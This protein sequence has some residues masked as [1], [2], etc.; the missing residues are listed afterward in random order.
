MAESKGSRRYGKGPKIAA[1]EEMGEK[2]EH[3]VPERDGD[4]GPKGSVTS[5]TDGIETRREEASEPGAMEPEGEGTMTEH[6]HAHERGAMHAKH[7]HELAQMHAKHEHE[8]RMREGGH[9]TEGHAEMHA[10]HHKE[11]QALHTEHEGEMKRMH[12]RH[13]AGAMEKEAA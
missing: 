3:T 10:R 13:E 1:K 4:K 8:H 2:V 9:H 5:G 6:M 12:A 11:R 7:Q